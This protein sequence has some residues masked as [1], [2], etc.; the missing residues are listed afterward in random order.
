MSNPRPTILITGIAGNLG[1]RLL[2]LL[3]EFQV[4]GVD[5]SPVAAQPDVPVHTLNLSR[6]KSCVQL[7][8]LLRESRPEAVV[9]LAS[10]LDPMRNGVTNQERM[11]QTNVA[12][13]ARV[14]EAISEMNRHGGNIRKFIYPSSVAV[15]GPE[16]APMVD[17]EAP[18]AAHTLNFAA[19]ADGVVRFR[20][21]SMGQCS[22]YLLRPQIFAGASAENY[23]V[24]AMRGVAHGDSRLATRMRRKQTRL[25]LLLPMGKRYPQKLFQFVHV[26]DVAR[27]IAW[28]LRKTA[29]QESQLVT[30]NVAGS[31]SPIGIKRCAEIAEARVLRLPSGWL[32]SKILGML[33]NRGISSVPPEAF[34]YVAGSYTMSTKRLRELLGGDYAK[35]IQYSTEAALRESFAE[36]QGAQETPDGSVSLK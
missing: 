4:I 18:V 36:A 1:S 33:W 9:H 35:V 28:L 23:L 21:D 19:E 3:S 27:L 30:L 8:S 29:P 20:A 16:T 15:Y 17:E 22:T 14:M 6:E 2:P 7:V 34:P 32:C 10:V 5:L 26:D 11:W 24:N 31:G 13:T 12:G 25:P